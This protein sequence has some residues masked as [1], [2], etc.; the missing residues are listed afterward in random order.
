MIKIPYEQIIEKIKEKSGLTEEEISSKVKEK[1][2]QLSGL[3]SNEGAAHI[4][5]NELGVKIFEDLSGKL[6]IKNILTGMR[7]VETVAKVTNVFELREFNTGERSGKVSSMIIGD[8]T[9]TI[10]ITMWGGQA[11]NINNIKKGDI[12][13][14]M[15]GYVRENQGRKEIHLNDRS[16]LII[17][18]EGETV[19]EVKLGESFTAP[20]QAAARKEIKNLTEK[21]SNIE[22]LGT[23]V[24]V[25]D[26][27]FYEVCPQCNKRVKP[28]GD[29]FNCPTHGDVEPGYA[30]VFNIMLDDG[31]ENIRTVFFREQMEKLLG[32]NNSE[33]LR[34]KDSPEE[35]A[36]VKND[37]LGTMIKVTGRASKN[38][39]FDRLEFVSRHV[40]PKPDPQ[41]EIERLKE[42]E[43]E[44]TVRES[45]EKNN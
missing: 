39:M 42:T 22:I 17:N 31:T 44:K 12:V 38:Q 32:K 20:Q 29:N 2:K 37:L 10:R 40:E 26:P 33:I 24:Q 23:V 9:G 14:I 16:K 11:D 7:D 18:P 8:E 27:R 36:A 4:V 35:F 19:G 30:Y 28:N 1:T 43:T 3:I 6:Q 5:A 21:D 25:Y 34:Y 45:I 15:S 13:K 41:K